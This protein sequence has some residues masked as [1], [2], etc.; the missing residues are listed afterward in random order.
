M[1]MRDSGA[2]TNAKSTRSGFVLVSLYS[3]MVITFGVIIARF[4]RGLIIHKIKFGADDATALA[5]HVRSQ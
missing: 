5:A 4:V 2:L 1:A 3:W